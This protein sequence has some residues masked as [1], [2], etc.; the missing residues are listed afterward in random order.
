[1]LIKQHGCDFFRFNPAF[2]MASI[3]QAFNEAVERGKCIV[4]Y[5]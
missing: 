1:M 5:N 2:N 4:W 3:K